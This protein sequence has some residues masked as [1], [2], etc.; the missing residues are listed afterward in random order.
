M[1]G[2]PRDR[3]RWAT[4]LL[5]AVAAALAATGC[6]TAR[7]THFRPA[8][9]FQGAGANWVAKRVY[10]LPPGSNEVK[11]QIAAR[12][13]TDENERGI[14][15]DTLHVRLEIANGGQSAFTLDPAAVKLL[16]DEGR[17]VEGAEA[18]AGRNRTGTITIAGGAGATYELVLDLPGSARLEDVGS[19]RLAWSYRY[20]DKT[21]EV[22]TKFIKI[23][24]VNYYYPYYY[25]PYY[26]YDPWYYHPGYGPWGRR[27][28][29][30]GYYHGW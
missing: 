27:R 8:G 14:A 7:Y 15:Y 6:S 16:D 23:E 9:E 12:G 20:G 5:V 30:F 28:F 22:T 10:D 26:D 24:Q 17:A 1:D 18:Y 13:R 29:G 4:G 21:H 2:A 19:L 11:V 3:R 25:P